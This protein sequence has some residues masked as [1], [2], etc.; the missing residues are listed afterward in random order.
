MR[1][2][3]AQASIKKPRADERE[4]LVSRIEM[5]V[6]VGCF[7]LELTV[8]ASARTLH[9]G[10]TFGSRRRTLLFGLRSRVRSKSQEE[11]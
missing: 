6:T 2:I 4:T 7:I 9:V 8:D 11:S 3:V 1:I 10:E 5:S